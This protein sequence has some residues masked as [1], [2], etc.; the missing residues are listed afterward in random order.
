MCHGSLANFMRAKVMVA[1]NNTFGLK[2]LAFSPN[3]NS[4]IVLAL[5][6]K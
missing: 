3:H 6:V 4:K 2:H 1:Q 5:D